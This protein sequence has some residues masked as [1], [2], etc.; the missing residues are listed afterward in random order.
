MKEKINEQKTFDQ[1]QR[2]DTGT[3]KNFHKLKLVVPRRFKGTLKNRKQ[4][5]IRKDQQENKKL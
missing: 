5:A 3:E 2:E 1:E 4:A